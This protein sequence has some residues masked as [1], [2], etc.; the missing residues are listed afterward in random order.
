MAFAVV[1]VAIVMI[2]L[3]KLVLDK[4]DDKNRKVS[5]KLLVESIKHLFS[6]KYQALLIPITIYSG[7]EQAFIT[8]TFTKVC[9]NRIR[10]G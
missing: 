2:F 1:A 7:I 10:I 6:S 3:D 4:E 5:A 8:G 9:S